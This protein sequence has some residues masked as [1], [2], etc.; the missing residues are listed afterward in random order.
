MFTKPKSLFTKKKI[1]KARFTSALFDFMSKY[2][3][4]PT[5]VKVDGEEKLG[6]G[7]EFKDKQFVHHTDLHHS[8]TAF[9]VLNMDQ[10]IVLMGLG[11]LLIIALL[12]NWHATLLVLFAV[13]TFIYF[14]DLVFNGALIY[15]SFTRTPEI[16]ITPEEIKALPE[17]DLPIYTIFCPLYKEWQVVPQFLANIDKLD[18]PKEKL[19]VM[20]LLEEDDVRTVQK[21]KGLDLPAY[22]EVVVVPDSQPKTKPKAMNYGL[23]KTRGKYLVIYDAEDAPEPDQLKKAYL[24]LLRLPPEVVCV[25]AKLNFYNPKQNLLTRLFS[26]EYSLWFDLVLT[27]LQT[28]NAPIPL[29]GTSNHFKVEDV[30]NLSGWDAF[31]VTE[32]CDLGLRMVKRG[33]RTAIIDSTT[34]EE[35][36]S[37]WYNW[38]RQRSRWIKGYIMT[39]LVHMRRPMELWKGRKQPHL[40]TFQLIVGAKILS[41]FINPVMW[42]IT[43]LYF[44]FRA[45]LGPTIETFFPSPVLYTGVVC[46]VAG[47][48]LNLYY[49]MIGLAKRQYWDLIKYAFVVPFYWLYM[50]VAAWKAVYEVIVKPHYWAKTVHGLHLAQETGPVIDE[51][52]PKTWKKWR[53]YKTIGSGGLL[54]GAMLASNFLNFLFSAVLGR[55]ISLEE[56]GTI[57]FYNTVISL[58]AIF[59]GGLGSSINH[60][61]SYLSGKYE[62]SASV[63]F[64]KKTYKYVFWVGLLLSCTWFLFS[65]LIAKWFNIQQ[66]DFV[67]AFSPVFLFAL[68]AGAYRGFLQ[69]RVLFV[70]VAVSILGEALGK[71]IFGIAATY[72]G[73]E[74]LVVLSVPV[75][76]VIGFL[77]AFLVGQLA[78]RKLKKNST[79]EPPKHAAN[80]PKRFYTAASV[81]GLAVAVFLSA[82][83]FLAKHYL[84][85]D[86][87]GQYGLLSLVG[88]MVY[89]IGTLLNVFIITLVSREAGAGRDP[90]RKFYKLFS[91]TLMLTI[92]AA[93][94][95]GPLGHKIVPL[96]LGDKTQAILPFLTGYSVATAMFALAATIVSFHLARKQYTF[97]GLAALA[98]IVLC[99]MLSEKHDTIEDFVFAELV[100]SAGYLLIVVVYHFFSRNGES[101]A[102][103][104]TDLLNA[105]VPLKRDKTAPGGK[106]ILIF[107]WRDTQHKFGGG[108]EVYIQELARRWVQ[109]GNAVTLF[110]G[111]D[112]SQL[113]EEYVDGVHIVR[114]GGFY[115]VY[116]WAVLY[117]LTQFR[118]KYD[119]IV[120]CHNGIP[121]FAPIYAREPVVAVLHHVHQDVF[122][123]FLPRPLA[124]FA[125]VLENR[126]M[127]WVYRNNLFITVSESSKKE[128]VDLDIVGKGIEIVH[129]GIDLAKFQP[130]KQN[131]D[132]TVLYLGRLKEYKS[133][134]ILLKAFKRVASG[135]PNA[136]LV[137]AGSGEDL[138]RLEQMAIDLG[139]ASKVKFTGKITEEEKTS[140]YQKA[141]VFVNPSFMEGW[142][143]TTIEANACGVPVVASA[144]PGLQDSVKNPHTGYL[145]PHGSTEEFASRISHILTNKEKRNWM[146][147][148]ATEWARNFDWEKS[149]GRAMDVINK[150]THIR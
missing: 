95:F 86:V 51:E 17:H 77:C 112:G 50:S 55:K 11:L 23:T 143:I 119:V 92:S 93:L 65:E 132:P 31:N 48:F 74:D 24:S 109:Q 15:R 30:K 90:N 115:F 149:A 134:D 66:V 127:P 135:L 9:F 80:F 126:L 36:N 146:R 32:D 97:V 54:V 122:Y 131:E 147:G 85:P 21:I 62:G 5:D 107:N 98:A 12:F 136:K 58:F 45:Q 117:Y 144:V 40:I 68:L 13:L 138:P 101:I 94:I 106:H 38:Y 16:Q 26:A 73:R 47:N 72:F 52:T 78:L 137:V 124:W 76:I 123:K 70:A 43:I 71:L 81:S 44:A 130:G 39:Y 120:D 20:F 34:Y 61:V 67:F 89:I 96:L 63:V 116:I 102:R 29:G 139:I 133:V 60:R 105:F 59:V 10:K 129:P 53:N 104:I 57:T 7:L 128:M 37:N 111:N 42:V 108:A 28:L 148:N 4:L 14:V 125:A 103:N 142:G 18:W 100:V 56:F 27:G 141:W 113:R 145:V 2:E 64:F 118:G 1:K 83:I 82:D 87:A 33:L 88:R 75:S 25:Q 99:S 8:E 79:Q 114:R 91:G 121:F 19:Q 69:A 46:L 41:L 3:T 140:F 49:Y 84:P 110:S 6:R 35:A 150:V 22:V